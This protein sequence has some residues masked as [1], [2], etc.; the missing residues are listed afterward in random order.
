MVQTGVPFGDIGYVRDWMKIT[1]NV[2]SPDILHPKRCVQGFGVERR[3]RSGKRLWGY[4][5]KV[6]GTAD[7]FFRR[8]YV[9]NYC[10]LAFFKG[11]KG[12]N[13]TPDR[14]PVKWRKAI[15]RVCDQALG[16]IIRE[17]RPE[18]VVGVGKF[19][20]S[21]CKSVVQTIGKNIKCGGILHPSPA[22]PASNKPPGWTL[23]A[24]EQLK[25]IGCHSLLAT[26]LK[27]TTK[28][29]TEK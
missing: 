10:P 28:L 26:G 21:R 20:E 22:N 12:A 18:F 23:I 24:Q 19:A 17:I 7:V 3:E 6:C 13:V 27:E 25:R 9:H 15:L 5:A 14:I 8:A 11:E 16:R 1:G 4:F 29:K 2:Y